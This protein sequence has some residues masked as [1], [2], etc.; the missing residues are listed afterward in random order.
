MQDPGSKLQCRTMTYSLLASGIKKLAT[1]LCGGRSVF[2]LEGGYNLESLS[3]SVAESF[4]AFIGEPSN[5]T[6]LDIRHF[7]F[8]EPLYGLS[9]AVKKIKQLHNL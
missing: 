3:D 2:F 4:R 5:S 8:Q 6:E 1:D 7:T 9:Q